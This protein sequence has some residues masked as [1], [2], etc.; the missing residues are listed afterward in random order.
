MRIAKLLAMQLQNKANKNEEAVF[1][2]KFSIGWVDNEIQLRWQM[3][4]IY[5]RI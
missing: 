5:K 3:P 2:P 4:T 1:H